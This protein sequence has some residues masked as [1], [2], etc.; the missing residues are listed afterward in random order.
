MSELIQKI[1]RKARLATSLHYWGFMAQRRVRHPVKREKFARWLANRRPRSSQ[2]PSHNEAG[3]TNALVQDMT[4]QGYHMLSGLVEP[5]QVAEMRAYFSERKARDPYRP[6]Y[7]EF[8]PLTE[9]R[10]ETHVAF[11]D[12][13]TVLNAPHAIALA[14]HPVLLAGVEALLGCKPSIGYVAAWW[15]LPGDGTAEHAE[16]FHRDVDDW[17]FYKFFLYL[18][19]VDDRSGPHM[20]V[21][22]SH[23]HT[24][25]LDIR[26]YSEA[27]AHQLGPEIRFTG[28]AGT[29]FLENTYGMHRGLP[30]RDRPRLIFQVTYCLVGLPYAPPAP[31]AALP[32]GYDPFVNRFYLKP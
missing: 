29:C 17:A 21:P 11:F 12:P 3:S 28:A 27:E 31:V 10:P 23:A 8:L 26:R 25:H 18:T 15:S 13:K 16:L 7:D 22:G 9:A 24:S 20:Y 14:N 2:R 6:T 4:R 30:P 5:Q 32:P 19:D 1:L